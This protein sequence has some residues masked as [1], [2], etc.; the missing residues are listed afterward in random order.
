MSVDETSYIDSCCSDLH[1]LYTGCSHCFSAPL[2]LW[3][4]LMYY[5]SSLMFASFVYPEQQKPS[6]KI[7]RQNFSFVDFIL[8]ALWHSGRLQRNWVN[9]ICCKNAIFNHDE[10]LTFDN[11]LY[12]RSFRPN[13]DLCKTV[14]AHDNIL[15]S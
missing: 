1:I 12:G 8:V 13:C 14:N 2:W 11:T 10:K 7:S 9:V 6:F 4:Q 5:V 15:Y 3:V